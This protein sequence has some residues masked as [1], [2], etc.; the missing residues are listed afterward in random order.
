MNGLTL[1]DTIREKFDEKV[2]LYK[3][4]TTDNIL[5]LWITP[6]NI[7][8]FL[9]YLRRNV[10]GPFRMLYDLTA[11]DERR[12]SIKNGTPDTDFTV[13]YHLTSI[14]R[15]EDIRIK[16]PLKGE[17]PSLP[18]ITSLWPSADW[19]EREIF[20][21]FGIVFEGHPDLRRILLPKSWKGH[22]LRKEYAARA[23]E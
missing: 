16:V 21:M 8:G 22:P 18:S 6:G 1:L 11:L 20:D 13:V 19:Y 12:R 3:Q 17:Y 23:T 5:T 15:N 10:R 4:D 14:E 2:I 7:V 9:K